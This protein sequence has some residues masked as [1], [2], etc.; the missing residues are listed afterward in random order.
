[1]FASIILINLAGENFSRANFKYAD[2]SYA[3][4]DA[5][6]GGEILAQPQY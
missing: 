4:L 6:L 5:S 3:N 1:M 2:L